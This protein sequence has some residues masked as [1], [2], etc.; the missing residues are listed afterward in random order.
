M[1]KERAMLAQAEPKSKV[2]FANRNGRPTNSDGTNSQVAK[3]KKG[4]TLAQQES[5]TSSEGEHN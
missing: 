2:Q 1:R 3:L 4:L 5:T